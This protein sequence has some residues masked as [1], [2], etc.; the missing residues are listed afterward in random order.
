MKF[1]YNYISNVNRLHVKDSGELS[2]HLL[3]GDQTWMHIE[4]NLK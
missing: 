4:K 2:R 1:T 3:D